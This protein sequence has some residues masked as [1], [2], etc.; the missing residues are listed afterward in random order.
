MTTSESWL[1]RL[2]DGYIDLE[3]YSLLLL[4]AGLAVALLVNHFYFR[5]RLEEAVWDG[6]SPHKVRLEA[7]ALAIASGALVAGFSG[8]GFLWIGLLL[9]AALL[10]AVLAG[11]KTIVWL[12]IG[13]FALAVLATLAGIKIN[14]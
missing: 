10:I 2:T 13:L 3:I 12:V 4:G 14:L 8:W 1:D 7:L 5:S 6:V 9:L 11:R